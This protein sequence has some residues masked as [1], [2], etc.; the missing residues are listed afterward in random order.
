[1]EGR[2]TTEGCRLRSAPSVSCSSYRAAL[3]TRSAADQRLVSRPISSRPIQLHW[4]Y[5]G[6]KS[7]PAVAAGGLRGWPPS[8]LFSVVLWWRL[9]DRGVLRGALAPC[10]PLEL[11]KSTNFW[12]EKIMLKLKHFWKCTPEVYPAPLFRFLNMPL[13]VDVLHQLLLCCRVYSVLAA[14]N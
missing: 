1:M 8:C 3:K 13:V 6:A 11:K 9:V 2:R 7:F 5:C 12:R 4:C 10:P 14:Y